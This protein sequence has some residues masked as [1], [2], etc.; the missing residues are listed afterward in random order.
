[1]IKG[2][3]KE[4]LSAKSILS[5]IS[6]YDIYRRYMP[7]K[8]WKINHVTYS[9]F[10]NE[11][12]PSFL[13]NNK[14]EALLFADFADGTKKGNCFDFVKMLYNISNYNDVLALIDKDFG[15]GI[16][17]KENVKN[18][19]AVKEIPEEPIKRYSLIQAVTRRFTQEELDYWNLY[20][21][22]E[23]DLKDNNIYSIQKVYLNRQLFALKDTD[24]RFGYF[25]EG[26]WKLYRPFVEKKFKWV[27]NNVPITTM[28]GRKDVEFCR[29]AFITKS[30]KDYMVMKKIYPHC[31]AVQNEGISCFS[32]EN[33]EYLKSN[34]DVQIL[35]FDNDVPGVSNSQQ[36]TKTFGFEYLNVPKRFLSEGITDWADWAK[37]YGMSPIEDYLKEKQLL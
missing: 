21:Q 25:Y 9:P 28:D 27:P 16:S 11:N 3:K 14:H 6:E 36:I 23:Q 10:R 1:M 19:Q 24:L 22:S 13:I 18:Y 29:M 26:H 5:K 32:P 35:S 4:E 33:V 34:S 12:N 20:H 37:N 7:N 8:D 15:L 17:S 31:C 2:V 30:K